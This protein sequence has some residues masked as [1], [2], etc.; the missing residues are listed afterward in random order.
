MNDEDRPVAVIDHDA[1]RRLD[2]VAHRAWTI[3]D[4]PRGM[5]I[6]RC[7]ALGRPRQAP[8][9]TGTRIVT[10]IWTAWCRCG[11][12]LTWAGDLVA[13]HGGWKRIVAVW[14]R[15][16]TR[17]SYQRTL[18]GTNL[19]SGT[20]HCGTGIGAGIAS[21]VCNVSPD[22]PMTTTAKCVVWASGMPVIVID[23]VRGVP[24]VELHGT[25]TLGVLWPWAAVGP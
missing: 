18:I 12:T 16:E 13:P 19:C 14:W 7:W 10:A 25:E 24:L 2:L 9:G 11:V 21:P 23:T 8:S 5:W 1:A 3:R 22:G 6:V 4:V 20:G 17:T 15:C